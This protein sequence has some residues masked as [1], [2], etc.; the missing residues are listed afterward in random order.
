MVFDKACQLID[1]YMS[2]TQQH[3]ETLRRYLPPVILRDVFL[4]QLKHKL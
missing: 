4:K 3:P 1:T 2:T